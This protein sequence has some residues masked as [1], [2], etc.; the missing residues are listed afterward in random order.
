MFL[1][2]RTHHA[3]RK[4]EEQK[5]VGGRGEKERGRKER[6]QEQRYGFDEALGMM[7]Q[8]LRTTT[9]RDREKKTVFVTC[10]FC[11]FWIPG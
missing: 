4:K 8:L 2:R 5:K 7:L 9:W 10:L 11:I 6:R 1:P 3:W